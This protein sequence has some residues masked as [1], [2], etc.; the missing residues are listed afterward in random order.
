MKKNPL[1]LN[2]LQLKTLA[3]AQEL[4]GDPDIAMR[5][6]DSGE[7]TLLTLPQPHGNHVHVGQFV[8]AAKDVSGFSNPAVWVV[9]DRKGLGHASPTGAVTITSDGLDYETGL[10]GAFTTLS[11][12]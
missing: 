5:D 2:K 6:D 11:D 3:L 9:L 4:A 7:V 12:H 10:A 1:K 8:V